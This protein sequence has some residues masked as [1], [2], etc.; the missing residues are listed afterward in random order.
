MNGEIDFEQALR[1]RVALLQG[2]S[3]DI[4]NKLKE[5]I[6]FNQNVQETIEFLK[7]QNVKIAV[8]SGGFLPIAEHVKKVL[9]L[10]FSFANQVFT[11]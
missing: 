4:W 3:S 2:I 7:E 6:T 11:F 5:R 9:H 1:Q 10:D 8:V